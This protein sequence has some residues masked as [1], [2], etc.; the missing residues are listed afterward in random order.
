MTQ[1]LDSNAERDAAAEELDRVRSHLAAIVVSSE[2]AIA[3]KDL[4]GVVT[5]WNEA[6]ERLFGYTAAEMIG[7]P[8]TRIIPTELSPEE[9]MILGRLRAGERIEGGN[10]GGSAITEQGERSCRR[11]AISDNPPVRLMWAHTCLATP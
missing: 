4:N 10:A 1:D 2:D 3:S 11:S 6:A 5:S 7:Q 8:I 9:A